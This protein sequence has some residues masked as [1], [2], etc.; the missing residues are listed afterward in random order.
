MW[1]FGI[2]AILLLVL[3]VAVADMFFGGLGSAFGLGSHL[4]FSWHSG[5]FAGP[6][7]ADLRPPVAGEPVSSNSPADTRD[8]RVQEPIDP[9]GRSSF[10]DDISPSAGDIPKRTSRSNRPLYR[11]AFAYLPARSRRRDVAQ[12]GR[13][14]LG[15]SSDGVGQLWRR[16]T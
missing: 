13:S 7:A 16:T 9:Q 4:P 11:G 1:R 2:A 10:R 12:P 6:D 14:P 8:S 15:C 3:V 5:G